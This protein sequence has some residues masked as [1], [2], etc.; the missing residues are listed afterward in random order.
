MKKLVMAALM[1]ALLVSCSEDKKQQSGNGDS[2]TKGYFWEMAEAPAITVKNLNGEVIANAQVLIGDAL[3]TPFEGN[4]LVTDQNGQIALPAGWTGPMNVTVQAAGYLRVTYMNQNP[5]SMTFQLRQMA[6]GPQYEIK[7]LARSLPVED[8]DG[9][10]DFG[11]VMPAFSKLD[12]L[13]FNINAVISPSVDRITVMGQ[14]LDVPANIS[15]PEQTEKYG[16]FSLTL[17]KAAYRI[18]AAQQGVKRVFAARGRFPFKSVVDDMRAGKEFYELINDFRINGGGIRDIDVRGETKLDVPTR[19]LNF[20]D[21]VEVAA[22]TFRADEIFMT[23]GLANQSGLMVPTDVKRIEQGKSLKV[24]ALPGSDQMVLGVLKRKSEMKGPGADRM[25][26]TLLPLT[27]GM[28]P[29]MLPLIADPS[30]S[31]QGELLFPKFNSINGVNPIATYSVL[32]R[33][34]E[35]QQGKEKVKLMMPRWEVYASDWQE[36]MKLPQWPNE[37]APTGK[38]RWEVSFIGSQTA[39]QVGPGPAMIEA[40]THVTHSSVSF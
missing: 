14:K 26:A 33:E 10:I 1:P 38:K 30:I 20:T 25:S 13:S 8:K 5:E 6:S 35:I 37:S 7:G 24:N 3:N 9:Y 18:Y 39:S 11:L 4:F 2:G 27:A 29:T 36:R 23:V 21:K 15:L 40:A 22:P 34:E 19:E 31:N 12:L 28:V 16:F 32:T 17:E